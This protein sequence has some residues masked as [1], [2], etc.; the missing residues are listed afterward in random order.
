MSIDV[1]DLAPLLRPAARHGGTALRRPR[2]ARD[3]R[4]CAACGS[5]A[6]AT[7]RPISVCS[8][9]RRTGALPSCRRRKGCEVALGQAGADRTGGRAPKCRWWKPPRTACCSSTRSKCHTI[10]WRCCARCGG[11]WRWGGRV[12]AVIPKR[13]GLWARMDTTPFGNG[14]PYSRSQITASF[15]RVLV[16][17]DRLGRSA[18]FRRSR[19][20]G[21]RSA[22]AW[23]CT[24]GGHLGAVRRRSHRRGDEAGLPA[25]P[26][27]A[28]EA[29]ADAGAR[30]GARAVARR[31]GAFGL[32]QLGPRSIGRIESEPRGSRVASGR[33]IAA[34]TAAVAAA[35]AATQRE[36]VR[37][38]FVPVR[39]IARLLRPVRLRSARLSVRWAVGYPRRR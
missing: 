32:P 11:C 6:S 14:R 18:L 31:R 1:V 27:A 8:A 12:L 35:A 10:R 2:G 7:P 23:E 15:A 34:R 30:T 26:G 5:S 13:R 21:L 19:A 37:R 36:A 29:P 28:R 3:G 33:T 20:T 9:R 24:A 25:G 16:H 4:T 39:A 22:P 38:S 17:A